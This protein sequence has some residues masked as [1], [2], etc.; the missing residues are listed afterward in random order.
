MRAEQRPLVSAGTL[1]GIGLGGFVDGIVFHQVLQL[2]SMLTGRLPK[3]TIAN[4]E[5]NMF[6]DGIFHAV[7]WLMTA[8]GVWLLFRAAQR[9]T[10]TWSSR[11]FVG[12]LALGWGLF[13][14]V[15]GTIDHQILGL[16]HVVESLGLS[17]FDW[18]FLASGG[19]LAVAGW[20]AIRS[21]AGAAED[22]S[23]VSGRT[24]PVTSR[25]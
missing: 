1:L 19:G 13:N 18:A 4:V 8:L 17:V 5:I 2:H 21:D 9:R 6:W 14:A 22:S 11:T 7:T 24:R 3:T 16:H 10:V 25:G 23:V 15:E 12:S 20:L